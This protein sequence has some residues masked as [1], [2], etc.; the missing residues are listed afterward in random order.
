MR[1]FK[2]LRQTVVILWILLKIS[3]MIVLPLSQEFEGGCR[4]HAVCSRCF[5]ECITSVATVENE[6]LMPTCTA[7]PEHT[8][9]LEAGGTVASLA[10]EKGYYRISAE[11]LVILECFNEDACV[12]G[13]VAGQYCAGGYTG[14]CT[15]RH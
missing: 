13:I 4:L 15:C 9:A 14:P 7:A 12:G 8:T 10:Q 1:S 6:Q 2:V 5:S 11:S 3:L